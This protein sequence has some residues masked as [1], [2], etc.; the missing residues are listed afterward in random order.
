MGSSGRLVT[1]TDIPDGLIVNA[2]VNAAAQIALAKLFHV[3]QDNILKSNGTTNIAGQILNADV[4]PGAAITGT[5]IAAGTMTN[6]L[7]HAD[8]GGPLN[9]PGNSTYI[10]TG[11]TVTVSG[12]TP[13]RSKVA[14]FFYLCGSSTTAGTILTIGIGVDS[15]TSPAYVCAFQTPA[16]A[17]GSGTCMGI[18]TATAPAHAYYGLWN[19]NAGTLSRLG[20]STMQALLL[21]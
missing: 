13:G 11:T 15:T 17:Y 19:G 2:D 10:Y 5:K 6:A 21:N 12:L 4:A 7:M 20:N 16:G 8:N 3:G 9:H 14:L 18:H 1:A